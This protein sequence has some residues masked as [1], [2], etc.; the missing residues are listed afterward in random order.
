MMLLRRQFLHLASSALALLATP[1]TANAEGYPS[2][3]ITIIVPFPAGG[4]GDTVGRILT[5]QLRASLGQPIIIENVSG[6]SGSIGTGR[7]ARA[8]PD[9]YRWCSATGAR[10]SSTGQST[11][12]STTS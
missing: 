11:R 3:P 12:F 1:W 9:G 4:P 6:A 7:V 10:M 8:V 5:D 2:R